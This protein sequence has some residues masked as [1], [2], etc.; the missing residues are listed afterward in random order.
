[1]GEFKD[2]ILALLCVP[3]LVDQVRFMLPRLFGNFRQGNYK[4]GPINSLMAVFFSEITNQLLNVSILALRKLSPREIN[5][6]VK[7]PQI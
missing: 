7:T 2:L 4:E 6:D 1:V 3:N 5:L